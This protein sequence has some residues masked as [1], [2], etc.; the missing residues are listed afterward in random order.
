MKP[1]ILRPFSEE[2]FQ[3]LKEH[4]SHVRR[5]Y[6]APGLPYHD[7]NESE[8]KRFNRFYFHNLPMLVELHH[9][10]D[11]IQLAS[12]VFGQPLKP[13]YVFLSMYG[14]EGICPPHTDRPQCKF[15][16]DLQIN[17]DGDWPI[18]IEEVPYLLKDGESLC[19][20]GTDQ[21]HYRN[22]MR[23]TKATKVDLAFFH[24]V[25]TNWMGRT[26]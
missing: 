4:V 21:R 7:C 14:P 13:S 3:K 20:S 19:Y 17:S 26:E 23:D 11:L 9:S 6:D 16:I 25:P 8:G 12:N 24:W 1:Q 10:P 22:T 18:F 2:T 5:V 15:T